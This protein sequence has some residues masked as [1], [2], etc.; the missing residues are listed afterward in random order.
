MLQIKT[1]LFSR[2]CLFLF[3]AGIGLH[4]MWQAIQLQ[5][6]GLFLIGAGI[7]G[8]GVHWFLQPLVLGNRVGAEC[9]VV[10]NAKLGSAALRKTVE[11]AA[12]GALLLG[13]LL[14]YAFHL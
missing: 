12:T 8:F 7:L 6:L 13:M 10:E 5:L 11:Y 14:R 1:Y 3:G 4:Q 2:I 9:Q